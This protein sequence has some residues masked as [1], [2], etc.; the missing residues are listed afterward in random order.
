MNKGDD[1]S[2][3][4][5]MTKEIENRILKK[6]R[7]EEGALCKSE[8]GHR[9]DS[10]I[11]DLKILSEYY[12]AVKNGSKTF[13]IR[14]NDRKFKVGDIVVLKEFDGKSY[15]KSDPIIKTIKYITNYNQA[16]D[17]VVFSMG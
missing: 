13:E 16:D 12:H 8:I 6:Q 7:R 4:D 1:L 2:N 11:H 15:V 17:F 10:R 14:K 9:L 5:I 3:K